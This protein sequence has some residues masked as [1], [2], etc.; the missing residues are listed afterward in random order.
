M[1]AFA[2]AHC[3]SP[4]QSNAFGPV[5]PNTYG[6]PKALRPAS[7]AVRAGS[8]MPDG[9][10]YETGKPYGPIGPPGVLP[11]SAPPVPSQCRCAES[12]LMMSRTRFASPRFAL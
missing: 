4:E 8:E 9:I 2:H 6:R 11:V 5:A 12:F 3:V 7:T 1:P 10:R